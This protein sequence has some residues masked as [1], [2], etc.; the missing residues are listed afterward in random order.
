MVRER[1]GMISGKPS[2]IFKS[3]KYIFCTALKVK[4]GTD[5]YTQNVTKRKIHRDFSAKG[6]KLV[7]QRG[8]MKAKIQAHSHK[9]NCHN[10]L[11]THNLLLPLTCL[12]YSCTTLNRKKIISLLTTVFLWLVDIRGT[13]QISSI[14]LISY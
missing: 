12:F 1:C 8:F 2:M 6:N 10:K 13:R 9:P 11:I 5:E 3:C 4:C 14:L 7:W